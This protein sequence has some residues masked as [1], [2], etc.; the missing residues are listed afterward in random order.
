MYSVLYNDCSYCKCRHTCGIKVPCCTVT[1]HKLSAYLRLT[2]HHSLDDF[3]LMMFHTFYPRQQVVVD[4]GILKS[5]LV[6]TVIAN[7]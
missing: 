5:V 4:A 2:L 3:P 6:M 7:M 1:S